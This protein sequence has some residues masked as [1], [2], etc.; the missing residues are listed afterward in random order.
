MYIFKVK[1]LKHITPDT[2]LLTLQPKRQKDRFQFFPGQYVAIGFKYHGRPSPMRCFSIVSSPNN[3]AELQLAMR[4]TGEF[5][6]SI[7]ELE[8]GETV[9]VHG[10]FG[11]FVIDDQ[12]DRNIV[13]I[14]G[15]IGITPF[16]SMIRYAAEARLQLPITLL[17]SNKYQ[18]N[19]PFYKELLELEHQSSHFKTVFFITNGGIDKLKDNLSTL[20]QISDDK[21]EQLTNQRY[22]NFTF[23][24]C[25]PRGF[26]KNIKTMLAKHDTDPTRIITEEFTPTSQTNNLSITPK[27]SISRMTYYL[28][29]ASLVLAI[30]FIMIVDLA[31]A[32]PKLISVESR[33]QSTINQTINS[34]SAQNQNSTTI[35]NSLTSNNSNSNSSSTTQTKNYQ[36]PITSVS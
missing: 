16:M 27:Y 31:R 5:T 19:I 9:F 6:S 4:I 17:Y 32:V 8:E 24:I 18:T 11:N 21:L 26:T 7:A 25:G 28:T 13:L 15:G 35:Q 10:P 30:G 12:L 20:G 22:N 14:A 29:G 2:L 3:K 23:F 33:Q 1:S 36:P 34:T